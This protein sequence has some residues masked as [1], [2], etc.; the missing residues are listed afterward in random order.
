MLLR[1][2]KKF[3]PLGGRGNMKGRLHAIPIMEA[4]HHEINYP[5]YGK[6][7]IHAGNDLLRFR[8]ESFLA[9]EPTTLEW[10][11]TL[12]KDSILI[13]VGA[14]I[15]IYTIPASLFHV[16]KVIA[17]EPEIKNYNMLL[18]NLK[19]NK[20]D[21]S[22]CE[23]IPVAVSTK[24][25]NAYT[26]LYLTE[27]R[28]GSS[29][30]QLGRNQDFKL[31]ELEQ[32]REYRT[33]GCISLSKI[34]R[35][36]TKDFDGRL[37]IKIDVDGIE[38]DVCE[39]IFEDKTYVRVS[40][41]QIELNP[42]I[43]QHKKLIENL[44]SLG[45]MY[46]K[47]QVERATRK[48]GAFKGFAEY[49]F[50]REFDKKILEILPNKFSG[51]YKLLDTRKVAAHYDSDKKYF[52]ESQDIVQLSRLP[53]SY[54][55]KNMFNTIHCS[56][57]FHSVAE[58]AILEDTGFTFSALNNK[59]GSKTSKRYKVRTELIDSLDSTY[60]IQLNK[61]ILS[62]LNKLVPKA[63]K[64]S[65]NFYFSKDHL[66]LCKQNRN[67]KKV[68]VRVRHFI[69]INGFSLG[70][71]YDSADT[72]CAVIAPI[73]PYSTATSLINGSYF[74]RDYMRKILP[75]SL[76]RDDFIEDIYYGTT[77]ERDQQT[78]AYF[79]KIREQDGDSY[80]F[81]A[82]SPYTYSNPKIRHGEALVIPNAMCSLFSVDGGEPTYNLLRNSGHGVLPGV[83]ELYRPV[84][85]IDY[86]LINKETAGK[87]EEDEAQFMMKDSEKV[88][89]NILEI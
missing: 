40:T 46:D 24:Y 78:F 10:L 9:K 33:V 31:R 73:F 82:S 35:Q 8:A 20:I 61:F 52:N 77:N 26:K 85:L 2:A 63:I 11:Q 36:S 19:L 21:C 22:T 49:I 60:Q 42:D 3:S 7:K 74:E 66:R 28:V 27:D 87:L 38:P 30:H 18:D 83:M 53:A 37:N 16:K 65:L 14:N 44:I 54:A 68:V 55:V 84:L 23:A 12:D 34:V 1:L 4:S 58:K 67:N 81:I 70:R 13:D 79:K 88:L 69:D 86:L 62:S 29:C 5:G 80:F 32:E 15:G 59:E 64:S 76:T 57:L 43:N 89:E 45:F 56:S 25:A 39:S 41:L 48:R 72:L 17:I 6:F 75:D 50:R 47:R 51:W 71:H